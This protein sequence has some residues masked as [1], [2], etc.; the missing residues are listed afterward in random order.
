MSAPTTPST[1]ATVLVGLEQA[2]G[3]ME[4]FYRHLHQHP[5]LS[6]QETETA[7]AVSQRL[8]DGGFEVA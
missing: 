7:A 4:D 5:E 6:H 1:A 3:W 2:R 8:T